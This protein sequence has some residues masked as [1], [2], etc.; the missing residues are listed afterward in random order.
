MVFRI[1]GVGM[2]GSGFPDLFGRPHHE[3]AWCF[4]VRQ[5]VGFAVG[6]PHGLEDGPLAFSLGDGVGCETGHGA[7][8]EQAAGDVGVGVAD[9]RVRWFHALAG[10]NGHDTACCFMCSCPLVGIW[11]FPKQFAKIYFSML[12]VICW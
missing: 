10:I 3:Q 9:A 12:Y 2:P 4:P 6:V 8:G 5:V 7:L 1:A 11:L